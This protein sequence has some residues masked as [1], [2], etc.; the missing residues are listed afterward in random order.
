MLLDENG[1]TEVEVN[2]RAEM[3][4]STVEVLRNIRGDRLASI[5]RPEV[6]AGEMLIERIGL[7]PVIVTG[8]A[9]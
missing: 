2:G 6:R 5:V 3:R 8:P 1:M 7:P 4:P 9:S